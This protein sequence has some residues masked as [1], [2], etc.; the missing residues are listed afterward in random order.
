MFTEELSKQP[1]AWLTMWVGG[2]MLHTETSLWDRVESNP[3]P[4]LRMPSSRVRPSAL[5]A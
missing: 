5:R 4:Q 2:R 1:R 3:G